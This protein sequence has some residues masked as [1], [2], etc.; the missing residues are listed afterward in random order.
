MQIGRKFK[1]DMTSIATGTPGASP[2][3][4][5]LEGESFIQLSQ[6]IYKLSN[7]LKV[8]FTLSAKFLQ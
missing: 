6:T 5:I 8:T 1:L 2:L 7:P 3:I 4:Q